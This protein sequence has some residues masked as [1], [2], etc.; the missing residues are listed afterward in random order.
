MST[1]GQHRDDYTTDDRY[2]FLGAEMVVS[3]PLPSDPCFNRTDKM[4]A[5][6]IKQMALWWGWGGHFTQL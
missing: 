4:A 1:P 5:E 3:E 6:D 2:K